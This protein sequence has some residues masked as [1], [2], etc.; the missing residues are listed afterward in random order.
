MKIDKNCKIKVKNMITFFISLCNNIYNINLLI[1]CLL[2]NIRINV[3][4][5]NKLKLYACSVIM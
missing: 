3:E 2:I 5:I 1:N 4:N